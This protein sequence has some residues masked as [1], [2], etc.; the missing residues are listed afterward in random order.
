MSSRWLESSLP[1]SLAKP[2]VHVL[3]GARRTGHALGRV[4]LCC[5]SSL[6]WLRRAF[7]VNISESAREDKQQS[8]TLRRSPLSGCHSGAAGGYRGARHACGEQHV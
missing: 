3:F 5:L 1:G 8:L 4:R 2:Y 7:R 6:G